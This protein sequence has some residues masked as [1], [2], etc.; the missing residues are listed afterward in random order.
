MKEY[1]WVVSIPGQLWLS[2]AEKNNWSLFALAQMKINHDLTIFK[3]LWEFL[4]CRKSDILL[5]FVSHVQKSIKKNTKALFFKSSRE[6]LSYCST[7]GA[8]CGDHGSPLFFFFLIFQ[9]INLIL[10]TFTVNW[11]SESL[12]IKVWKQDC[13]GAKLITLSDSFLLVK[14]FRD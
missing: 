5:S 8:L 6:E 3:Q 12:A 10:T 1:T 13:V 9:Q 14:V 2:A 4:C 7:F 11:V